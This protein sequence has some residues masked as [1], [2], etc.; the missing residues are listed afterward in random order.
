MDEDGGGHAA[1]G[2]GGQQSRACVDAAA[3]QRDAEPGVGPVA[4]ATGF[5]TKAQLQKVQTEWAEAVA[6]AAARYPAGPP[7]AA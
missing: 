5:L 6:A 1:G 7:A 3:V 4:R 2:L